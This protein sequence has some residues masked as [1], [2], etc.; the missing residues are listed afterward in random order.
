ME[1]HRIG[2]S[3]CALE[4]PANCRADIRLLQIS[5]RQVL[6]TGVLL[7]CARHEVVRV[8]AHPSPIRAHCRVCRRHTACHGSNRSRNV[9]VWPARLRSCHTTPDV[10][11]ILTRP[12]AGETK[13]NP[14]TLIARALLP[15]LAVRIPTPANMLK[16]RTP[17]GNRFGP[18]STTSSQPMVGRLRYTLQPVLNFLA[19]HLKVI[20]ARRV[21]LAATIRSCTLASKS[22][23]VVLG[24]L[25]PPIGGRPL[26]VKSSPRP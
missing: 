21:L 11:L 22:N 1:C 18:T 3:A 14:N 6:A 24:L 26:G 19:D 12:L 2:G 16:T 25:Q 5:R 4:G 8:Q 7:R 17:L 9:R 10:P 13:T 20:E 23:L 15:F